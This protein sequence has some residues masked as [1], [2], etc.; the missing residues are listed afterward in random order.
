MPHRTRSFWCAAIAMAPH[1]WARSQEPSGSSSGKGSSVCRPSRF[2]TVNRLVCIVE[3]EGEVAAIPNL[4]VRI[5]AHLG[6]HGWVVD[7]DPIRRKRSALVDARQPKPKRPCRE[8]EVLKAMTL[9]LR[10][11]RPA[12]A[13]LL[14]CDEDEDC[15]AIWGPDATRVMNKLGAGA[16][17][18][19]VPEYEA[20]LLLS[21]S[22]A[23]LQAARVSLL[24]DTPHQHRVLARPFEV[25]RQA[26]AM[27]RAALWVHRRSTFKM[28]D[29][30]PSI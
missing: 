29:R 16:A 15:A 13:V 14:L 5:M 21:H 7:P 8:D 20:W 4:C 23:E 9:A 2:Q 1:A 24:G 27:H 6:V 11:P 10:R 28:K 12:N 17:V 25:L 19:V 22:D 18:I 3:G 26:G 30:A